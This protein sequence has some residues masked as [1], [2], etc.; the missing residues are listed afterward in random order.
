[1]D[2]ADTSC[3]CPCGEPCT[4]DH[5]M[6]CTRGGFVIQ[7]H[8]KLLD[9]EAELLNMV[10]KDLVTEPVLQDVEGEQLRK[11]SNKAQDARLDI[12]A[13]GFWEFVTR[14][15]NPI[16][17]SSRSKYIVYTRTRKSVNT[18][19]ECSISNMEHGTFTPLI[20][21][22]E[23]GKECLNYHSRLAELIAIKRGEDYAKLISWIRAITSFALLRSVLI[24]LRGTRSTVRKSWDFCNTDIEIEN[25]EEAIY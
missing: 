17:T 16:G 22:G 25:T 15:L 5:A 14:M 2:S 3:T 8:N 13:H 20:F 7:K 23:M 19:A 21:T 6:I 12:H 4:V 24:C 18:Q 9:L 1:M 10:C 11:G